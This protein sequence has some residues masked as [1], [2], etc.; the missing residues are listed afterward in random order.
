MATRGQQITIAVLA[1]LTLFAAVLAIWMAFSWVDR[2]NEE[3]RLRAQLKK[4][5]EKVKE[6]MVL[7]DVPPD[8][9]AQTPPKPLPPRPWIERG[10][11]EI[12]VL[13]GDERTAFIQAMLRAMGSAQS[14]RAWPAVRKLT[15]LP[16][17]AVE[18]IA[19]L[20]LG[21]STRRVRYFTLRALSLGRAVT[22]PMPLLAPVATDK[23]PLV[24]ATL[25][26]TLGERVDAVRE[27]SAWELA[28]SVLLQLFADPD[29]QVVHQAVFALGELRDETAARTLAHALSREGL[30]RALADQICSA[31]ERTFSYNVGVEYKLAPIAPDE[32]KARVTR[33]VRWAEQNKDISA[34]A[35][36]ATEGTAADA[37]TSG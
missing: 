6:Q 2:K 24:R 18:E 12:E 19:R 5:D 21:H 3:N 23:D 10:A 32:H 11:G 7:P 28:R 20:G 34:E 26:R 33:W 36:G 22:L 31:L 1:P 25:A 15:A 35:D 30:D 17:D 13:K 9:V 14:D 27:E 37:A 4:M 29:P 16:P 8:P